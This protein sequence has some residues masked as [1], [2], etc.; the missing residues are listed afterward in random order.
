MSA[1]PRSEAIYGLLPLLYMHSKI[2]GTLY[3]PIYIV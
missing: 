3:I 2:C 1:T